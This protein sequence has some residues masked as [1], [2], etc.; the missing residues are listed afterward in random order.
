M[1]V[2]NFILEGGLPTQ[3]RNSAVNRL[4]DCPRLPACTAQRMSA[5]RSEEPRA[6]GCICPLK[7]TADS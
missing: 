6:I 5:D 2:L 7:V 4:L 1:T 3:P